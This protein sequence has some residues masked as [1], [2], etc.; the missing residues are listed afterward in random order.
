MLGGA[1]PGAGGNLQGRKNAS[2]ARVRGVI[3]IRASRKIVGLARKNWI[4]EILGE[5]SRPRGTADRAGCYNRLSVYDLGG[6]ER[7]REVGKIA[8]PILH[9]W[10]R[11]Q[12][13][14]DTLALASAL[15]VGKEKYFIPLDRSAQS[16]AKLILNESPA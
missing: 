14:V 1:G 2:R 12:P 15:V 7:T 3:C 11:N 10:H 8:V 5:R 13:G 9:R 4:T 16:S 6:V